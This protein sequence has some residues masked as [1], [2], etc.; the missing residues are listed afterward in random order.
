MFVG[1]AAYM[2]ELE[3]DALK[4]PDYAASL[5]PGASVIQTARVMESV[6]ALKLVTVQ[7]TT[8]V[9][10]ESADSSWR[11]SA[12]A[13]V[14]A[15]VKLSFGTDLSHLGEGAVSF[16][17]LMNSCIVRVPPPTR[18]ATEVMGNQEENEVHVG[19][20]RFRAQAGEKHLGIARRDLY[21][22]ALELRLLAEDAQRV[23]EDTR[24]QVA[25]LIHS[26]VGKEMTLR[27]IFADEAGGTPEPPRENVPTDPSAP[28]LNGGPTIQVPSP[29]SVVPQQSSV[30]DGTGGSR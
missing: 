13:T 7:I 8:R 24:T 10:S 14:Q 15:P 26:I 6:R 19:W 9:S 1:L 3:N 30:P 27:V 11:G 2:R 29:S 21:G 28:P 23:R 17:P 25:T 16:S 20:L 5:S 22:Q 4:T 12:S 18:I